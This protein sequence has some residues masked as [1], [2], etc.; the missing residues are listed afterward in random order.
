[1]TLGVSIVLGVMGD[2]AANSLAGNEVVSIII[3]VVLFVVGIV[4]AAIAAIVG[5]AF[6]LQFS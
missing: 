6:G 5:S 1:M 2:S 3:G 4:L